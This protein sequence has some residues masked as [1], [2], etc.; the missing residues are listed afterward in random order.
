MTC[1]HVEIMVA[2]LLVECE[3]LGVVRA[4]SIGIIFGKFAL[5]VGVQ[6]VVHVAVIRILGQVPCHIADHVE[7][8]VIRKLECGVKRSVQLI[9]YGTRLIECLRSDCIT[10]GTER[11]GFSI[12]V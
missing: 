9:T 1:K 3:G 8:Q 6:R 7:F 10:R 2:H 11:T 5:H 4:D 12:I